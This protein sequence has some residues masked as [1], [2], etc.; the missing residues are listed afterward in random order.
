MTLTAP[1]PASPPKPPDHNRTHIN[2]R[3]PMPRPNVRGPV[4]D[5]HCHLLARRHGKVWFEAA[6]HYGIDCFVTMNQLDEAL[7]LQR[8]FPGKLHFIAVAKWA[9]PDANWYDD[10]RRRIEAFYNLGSRIVKFHQAPSTIQKRGRLDDPRYQPILREIADRK[11][12]IMTHVGDPDTWYCSKYS[13]CGV[14]GARDDHYAMWES[15]MQQYPDVPWIGAHM[16]GNPEN[17]PRLQRLLD[18][19]PNLMLDC[20]ATRWMVR[21]ISARRD[22]AREFF[23]HNADRILFGSDQVS[24][25]DRGFD[26]LA[27]RF[28]AHRKLWETAYIG[29]TPIFDPDLPEDQQPTLRGLALPDQTLQKMYHDNAVNFLAKVGVS[30]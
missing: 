23:I 12:A 14:F 30:L 25:D 1:E 21:E 19:Y 18:R 6:A 26:F 8:D 2:F 7:G 9:E 24:G 20:S 27:S 3:R 4:I 15:V 28:W 10:F 13:D 5:F 11:M 17:L 29:Q 16:A 22:E